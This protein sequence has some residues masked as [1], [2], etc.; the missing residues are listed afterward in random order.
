MYP[1]KN[2]EI[3]PLLLVLKTLINLT[4]KDTFEKKGLTPE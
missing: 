1:Q 4:I 3:C 2:L